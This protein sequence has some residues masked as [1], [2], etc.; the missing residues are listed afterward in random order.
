MNT[1]TYKLAN[2]KKFQVTYGFSSGKWNFR[3]GDFTLLT[4]VPSGREGADRIAEIL[5]KSW[6]RATAVDGAARNAI[7]RI[8]SKGVPQLKDYRGPWD[9]NWSWSDGKNHTEGQTVNMVPPPLEIRPMEVKITLP[10]VEVEP[11][12]GFAVA[13]NVI[14]ADALE[15][16]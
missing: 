7:N 13:A 5:R 14:M 1:K 11:E 2:K 4:K 15:I 3:V 12:N 16:A 9:H 10:V 8:V 6:F